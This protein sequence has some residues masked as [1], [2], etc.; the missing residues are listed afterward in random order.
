MLELDSAPSPTPAL[1]GLTDLAGLTP[2]ELSGLVVEL[3]G[4]E[5]QGRQLFRWIHRKGVTDFSAMTNLPKDLRARL[6]DQAVISTPEV[7]RKDTS[8]DGTTKLLLRLG[9]G[10]Q[11]EAVFIPDTPS[12]TFCIST[13][14]GCAMK[15]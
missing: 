3:G 5:F 11:I 7:V 2:D 15:C 13:Q 9:D 10:R 14:V 1:A 6:A 8:A 4:K 12:Q